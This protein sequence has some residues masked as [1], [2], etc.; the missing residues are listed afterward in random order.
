[1]KNK[2]KNKKKK[3]P[4]KEFSVS[5]LEQKATDCLNSHNYRKAREYFKKLHAIDGDKYVKGLIESLNG[6][7]LQLTDAG[8]VKEAKSLLKQIKKLGNGQVDGKAEIMLALKEGDLEKGAEAALKYISDAG[9][10]SWQEFKRVADALVLGYHDNISQAFSRF[11]FHTDLQAIHTALQMVTEKRYDNATTLLRQVSFSS[12]FSHWKLFIKG[13]CAFYKGEDNRAQKSL[14]L[15]PAGSML[16]NAAI[17]YLIL[18]KGSK[19]LLKHYKDNELLRQACVLA[20]KEELADILPRAEYL[21][22]TNRFRDSF[23]HVRSGLKG[24]PSNNPGISHTLAHFYFN[25]PLHMQWEQKKKLLDFFLKIL[26]SGKA[27]NDTET[28]MIIRSAAL[29]AEEQDIS[30]NHLASVWEDFLLALNRSQAENKKLNAI[31]Y[32]HI[33]DMFSQEEVEPPDF[34]SFFGRRRPERPVLRNKTLACKYYENSLELNPRDRDVQFSFLELYEKTGQK[35]LINRKLDEIIKLFPE[36]KEALQKAGM[37]CIERKAFQKGLKYLTRAVELDPLDNRLREIFVIGCIKTARNHAEKMQLDRFRKLLPTVIDNGLDNSNNFNRGHA[38]LYAR[39]ANFELLNNN[40]EEARTLISR[41]YNSTSSRLGLSYFNSL[42]AKVYGVGNKYLK[43]I[44]KDTKKTFSGKALPEKAVIFAGI[45]LYFWECSCLPWL[46]KEVRRVNSYAMNAA[47]NN[48]TRE[49]ALV[50]FNFAMNHNN[51]NLKLAEKY[52][53]MILK[54]NPDDPLF[55]FYRY[56]IKPHDFFSDLPI[57]RDLEELRNILSLAEKE[58]DAELVNKI[59]NK[60]NQLEKMTPFIDEF[61]GTDG[62]NP[63][64]TL[65]DNLLDDDFEDDFDFDDIEDTYIPAPAKKTKKKRS[66]KKSSD[67]PG[68][69]IQQNLFD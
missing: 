37:R 13:L 49:Q 42:I 34:F 57:S 68:P 36:D 52:I 67:K 56:E 62:D 59:R 33:G 15:L 24:F 43:K 39:W 18:I 48:C 44:E 20:G 1:M 9:D 35:P 17:P 8:Q 4:Q 7:V 45:I 22:R 46:K 69:G 40:T 65:L 30:D 51:K 16:V 64:D 63:F 50:I 53:E 3:K 31:V 58:N 55:L 2:K 38:F 32:S 23:K 66:K 47:K 29:F 10:N 60:I 26:S 19:A 25:M 5:Q 14:E 61:D 11:A 6:L 54:K 21:W 27:K 12:P 28:F 41:A